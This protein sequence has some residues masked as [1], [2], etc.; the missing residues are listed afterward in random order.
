MLPHDPPQTRFRRMLIG[1]LSICLA[2]GA[3]LVTRAQTDRQ[4]E[5][6]PASS[7]TDER[8][9]TVRLVTDF[10]SDRLVSDTEAFDEITRTIFSQRGSR[11]IVLGERSTLW[12]RNAHVDG[13]H[14]FERY[15]EGKYIGRESRIDIP[16]SKLEP[17]EHFIQPGRHRFVVAEDGTIRSDDPDIRVDGDT[18]RLR[19]YPVTVYG[20]DAARTGPPEFR[21]IAADLGVFATAPDFTLDMENLPDP[22]R[23]KDIQT[24]QKPGPITNVLSHQRSFY[25]LTVW[26]PANEV[27][28]GYL[29]FPSWQAF[30]LTP[31]GRVDLTAPGSALVPGVEAERSTITVPYRQFS[32][33]VKSFTGLTGGVGNV[34][35]DETMNFSA[36]LA[37]R[38]FRAGHGEPPE[39]FHLPVSSDLSYRPN[40]FFLAD[41]TTGD[42]DA[43]RLFALEWEHPVLRRGGQVTVGLRL[44]Q[45]KDNPTVNSPTARVQ[46]SPYDPTNPR[47]RV[48]KP[49]EV[50]KW[51]NDRQRGELTFRAPDVPPG[52]Y[53]LRAQVIDGESDRSLT[54]LAGEI[55]AAVVE[56]NQ[57]GTASV[58]ANRNR[59]AFVA[60]EDIRLTLV[61]RSDA[62]RP[63][64]RRAMVLTHPDGVRERIAFDDSGDRWMARP[65]ILPA[66]RTVRMLTG[67]Y[68]LSVDGL[69][70][71]VVA[72]P[73]EFE[74]AG[75]DRP[76]RYHVV[77][78]S[79]YTKPM[80][81]LEP[82]WLR[83]E[84]VDLDRAVRTLANLGYN[85][86]DL[87]SYMT[88]KHL[89]AY[90]WREELVGIDERLP[91]PAAVYTPAPRDQILDACTRQQLQYSDVWLSYNDFH[92]PR[93]IES[94]IHASERWIAR[95]V[96]AM[97]YSPAFDGM[98]LYDEMYQ[99]AVTGIVPHHQKY[100]DNVRARRV[101]DELGISPARVEQQL[102]RYL[103]KPRSQRQPEPLRDYIRYEDWRQYGWADYVNH[104][105]KVGRSLDV[106]ARFGTYHR[107]WA[108]P[109]NNDVLRHGYPPDLFENLDVISHVHYADNST[110]WVSIPLLARALR[111]GTDKTLY[112]NHPIVHERR[113]KFDGQ[114]QRQMAF[115][116]LAQGANGISQWGMRHSF[117]DGP[118]PHT[119]KGYETTMRL[120][121]EI[122]QPF[123]E[124]IDRTSDG[125]RRIGIVS[126][127]N[128]HTLS[129]FK[130][131][132]T[133]NQTEGVWIACWRLGYPA[134]FVREE[135]VA[136]GVSDFDV[137]FVPGVRFDHELDEAV[138]RGLREA[139][140]DG[141]KVVVEADSILP[142]LLT[143]VTHL[144]DW[145]L[146]SYFIGKY[147]AT[148]MDDELNKVYQKSQPI[149]DYL[150]PKLK[151]W[152]VE[153]AATG[154]FKVGPGWRDGGEID[155]LIM[156]NFDD[157]D[158]GHT[159]KQQMAR[160][161]VMPMKVPARRGKVAYDLL[162]QQRLPLGEAGDGMVRFDLDMRRIQGG[163]VGFTPEPVKA[164]QVRREASRDPGRLRMSAELIGE[165]GKAIA[166][167][168][169]ARITVDDGRDARQFHRVLGGEIE[170]TLDLPQ[171]RQAR[172]YTVTVREDLSGRTVEFTASVAE[173]SAPS[174][175]LPDPAQARVPRPEEVARFLDGLEQ[176]TIIPGTAAEGAATVAASLVE[177][178]QSAGID[179]R[180]VAEADA[181][182]VPRGDVE[183]E[184]PLGDGF[185]S[186]RGRQE[187][188]APATV[189]DG[190]VILLG[191]NRGSFLLEE[192]ARYGYLSELPIGGPGK[193]VQ[194][195]VQVAHKA[196]HYAHDT[197]CL[198]ANDEVGLNLAAEAAFAD[199]PRKA[200]LPEPR[201]AGAKETRSEQATPIT[202]AASFGGT[203][204]LVL[205]IKFDDAGNAYAI[206]WG[207][208]KNLY[209]VDP[210]G[211]L[212]FARFLPEMGTNELRVH[213]DRIYSYTAAGARL[214]RLTLDGEPI[215][216]ARL[217]MDPG[218]T[219]YRDNYSLSTAH[220]RYLPEPGWLL[221][222]RGE[223]VRIY[224]D[225][226]NIVASWKG[227]TFEDRD[228][229]DKIHRRQL[230]GYALSSDGQRIAQLETSFYY[231]KWGPK[232][233]TVYDTHLVIR[234]LT[235]KLL[236]EYKNIDN[237]EEV[238]AKVNWPAGS[239]GPV[240]YVEG[241]RWRFDEK[242]ELRD[243]TPYLS[244]YELGAG[245]RLVRDGRSLVY[246]DAT[247]EE[248]GRI[249]PLE[250]MPSYAALSRDERLIALADE[251][252]ELRVH[253][254]ND[255]ALVTR[256][257]L[258]QRGRAIRFSPDSKRLV[259]GGF[260]GE[261]MAYDLSG[262][263]LWRVT[264][265]EHNDILGSD[266]PL[267]DSR[268]RDYT[269]KVWP[270]R[271]DEPGELEKL[272]RLGENRLVNGGGE[273]EGGWEGAVAF[274]T[275]AR[276][277]ARAIR[278][279]PEGVT[280]SIEQYLGEHTTWV[281][282]FH[283]RR[284]DDKQP[285]SLLAGVMVDAASDDSVA[286]PFE[287]TTAWR[288]G[289]VVVKSGAACER[290]TAGFAAKT[291]EVLV[292]DATFRRIR[293]PS[294]NHLLYPPL[295]RT[296]PI[297][298]ENPLFSQDY[299]PFGRLREEAPSRV[300]VEQIRTGALNLVESA[301][302]QNGRINEISSNWYIQPL[303][304]DPTVSVGL[305]DSRWV[306]TVALYFNVYDRE[307]VTP[308][309]DIYA[310]SVED[311]EERLVASV[312]HNRQTFRLVKFPPI[313]TPSVKIKFVNSIAR[314]RTLTEVE[315]Y[316]PLSGRE[317]E[318]RFLDPEGQNAYMG[319]FTR[320][321]KRAKHL[322]EAWGTPY[323]KGR[324]H[325]PGTNWSVPLAQVLAANDTIYLGRAFGTNTAHPLEKPGEEI[326]RQRVN[327]LGWTRYGS[328]YAG[329]L[330][331]SG[332]DGRL[333]CIDAAS[334]IGRAHV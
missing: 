205:D 129:A 299:D 321:D 34:R 61:V 40:K 30:H 238:T 117:E 214:Y 169:P 294:I 285:A 157:P 290:L 226:F 329:L 263:S 191:G 52:F 86:V 174:I 322:P 185:H 89:R 317:G 9:I 173:A 53:V 302:L 253:K 7:E 87:M 57:T 312:R 36:T 276:R 98:M 125:Y 211:K 146:N 138:L 106:D 239:F 8:R 100:F 104:V 221:H 132:P 195:N 296:R 116:L 310:T 84:P 26:L 154:P 275:N 108:S 178:L 161:V 333:Y 5:A 1:V 176:V 167:V 134:V 31:D 208:G 297:V 110:C 217:N 268:Y 227:E 122:L 303:H 128:Q 148:W 277:G 324:T 187:V 151:E 265:G 60:G 259:V 177:R 231:T 300:I 241:K 230:H 18:I 271:R 200:P 180:I 326:Y 279:G 197:L 308:H 201:F 58:I 81:N 144:K 330:L 284:A 306:S 172:T 295:Y 20:V 314:L 74:L 212:R 334:E 47:S 121:R 216:Q 4:A 55:R 325:D 49:V 203:N 95:E 164:M 152:G 309:F 75:R 258:P 204:E 126:T 118:N 170:A 79:K 27:G 199:A 307:H 237:A 331:R 112:I 56:A 153:P 255:G 260:R 311:G 219:G 207:H 135:H 181:W 202:P 23:G 288:F 65:L 46:W 210:D 90:T 59:S 48:W 224:D 91:P 233:V 6:D 281:L 25:P 156:A 88:N 215:A 196:L 220:F 206:T 124:I 113:T 127:M 114:Y 94:Y 182:L 240:V 286:L 316:G 246:L 234:D 249:G 133:A 162:A 232:D 261:I 136:D 252:G 298:L 22:T 120:N 292:D 32:G 315:V 17:G 111:T 190:P 33:E 225:A 101:S 80:N 305:K 278:V 289:R 82:G 73:F 45:T 78:T 139:I 328:L 115:A 93:Y 119:A 171:G 142:E 332:H 273:A 123:G 287:A 213:D 257:D 83:G 267:Y 11:T 186:W 51:T 140:A 262:E 250:T 179:A 242:L 16:A 38:K 323:E 76:S 193:P 43:V 39:D 102:N 15:Y 183:A 168:F 166:G 272:V 85:R 50:L 96:Q 71:D 147:F 42:P 158:Y 103:Q 24:E 248:H 143:G 131:I 229:S 137:L 188:I 54:P 256:I 327:G 165:S 44:L 64:G 29:L 320:V 319:D 274:A 2:L 66:D 313:K 10:E 304:H 145:P 163:L 62:K 318:P 14:F 251:Y 280:Q 283:Y 35:L 3:V 223:E 72:L 301:Y 244:D 198:I 150:G 189:V 63:A 70:D 92:L 184:D 21:K 218:S 67:T 243:V 19:C 264:L 99:S 291:G 254:V 97:R 130:N 236:H 269:E 109:G 209:S 282:E 69:P 155:Y 247:D 105:V 192:I 28:R 245:R 37:P 68:T 175:T 77:K 149:V 159:V 107:T 41:N 235:G 270:I 293:F 222:N 13:E 160:P 141:V 12:V 194:P 266:L 228:V